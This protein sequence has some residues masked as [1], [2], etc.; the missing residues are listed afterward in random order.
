[1]K[2]PTKRHQ[3]A[4]VRDPL[5]NVGIVIK[6]GRHIDYIYGLFKGRE[7][8]R[9]DDEFFEEWYLEGASVPLLEHPIKGDIVLVMGIPVVEI[10][11][12]EARKIIKAMDPT[13]DPGPA[14]AA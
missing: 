11:G 9:R 8:L 12:E 2:Q 4:L 5:G 7:L 1:M 14:K 13:Y 3:F 10:E 6:I